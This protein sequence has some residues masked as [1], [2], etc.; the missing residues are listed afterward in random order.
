MDGAVHVHGGGGY[1]DGDGGYYW[2][3]MAGDRFAGYCVYF[4]YVSRNP[5]YTNYYYYGQSVSLVC[6]VK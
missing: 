5:R 1:D 4:T 2:T 6:E 3:T